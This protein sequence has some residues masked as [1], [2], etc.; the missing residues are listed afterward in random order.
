VAGEL[1]VVD[2]S[3]DPHVFDIAGARCRRTL[4]CTVARTVGVA[5]Q[6]CGLDLREFEGLQRA[7]DQDH[8]HRA[9]EYLRLCTEEWLSC[10]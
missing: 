6:V 9:V 8:D 3:I 5:F 1:V 10:Q 7:W 4:V 2:I